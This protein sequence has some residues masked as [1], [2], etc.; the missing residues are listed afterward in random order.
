MAFFLATLLA[1]LYFSALG[2]S[3]PSQL[4]VFTPDFISSTS[5]AA[6]G[7]WISPGCLAA[8]EAPVACDPSLR[9]RVVW[10]NGKDRKD[11]LSL[12]CTDACEQSLAHY[13]DSV[14]W[15]CRYDPDPWPGVSATA[16][17]DSIWI[18]YNY[19]CEK[20]PVVDV[21]DSTCLQAYQQAITNVPSLP[22]L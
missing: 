13:H 9:A 22:R 1:C 10:S 16:F 6:F 3:A 7:D 21:M 15:A 18:N 5:I 14:L 2:H 8:M 12:I 19:T 20:G 17:G 11:K 4:F